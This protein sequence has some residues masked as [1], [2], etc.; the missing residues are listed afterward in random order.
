MLEVIV[1]LNALS[2]DWQV[3]CP[4]CEVWRGLNVRTLLD[5]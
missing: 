5:T 2:V 3:Y 1:E 4:P